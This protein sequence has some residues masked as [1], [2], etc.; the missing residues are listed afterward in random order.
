MQRMSKK[1]K[2][3][4]VNETRELLEYQQDEDSPEALATVPMLQLS[5]IPDK[6][7]FYAV[8]EAGTG[9][10]ELM[11]Y[12][13]FTNGLVYVSLYF[14]LRVLPEE[15][16]P[17]AAMMPALLGKLST[18]SHTFGELDNELNLHTGGFTSHLASYLEN[19]SDENIFPRLVIS[20]KARNSDVPKML[21]LLTGII[22]DSRFRDKERLKGLL[23]RHHAQIEA[24]IRQN[25]MNYAITRAASRYSNRGMFNELTAGVEYYRFLTGLTTNFDDQSDLLVKKL[26]EVASVLFSRNNMISQVTCSPEDLPSFRKELQLKAERFPAGNARVI[27]WHFSFNHLNEAILSASQVQYVVQGYDFRKLGYTWNGKIHVLSQVIS[28]DWL[29]NQIRVMGGAYGGFCGFSPAGN[30]Y[31]ASYRDPG[32]QETLL[33]YAKTA[34]YLEQFSVDEPTMNRYIIGTIAGL[35]QPRTPSQQGSAAMHHYFEK[36]TA[37]MLNR[38]RQEILTTTPA[39]IRNMAGMVRDII[40]QNCYCVYGNENRILANKDLFDDLIRLS[41]NHNGENS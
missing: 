13:Q 40:Q 12:P 19:R 15:L 17:Y 14:Q 27:P 20:S 2:L 39:D 30:V 16:I 31:F 33:A 26:E 6:A 28:T 37:G 5:D 25:G 41:L 11:H 36:T 24:N 23:T 3:Q 9:D 22:L 34:P 29:Q 21:E 38:E 7:L 35:D 18:A 32:L 10:L 8:E 1:R 4:L